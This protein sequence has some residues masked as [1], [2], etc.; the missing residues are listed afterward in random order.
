MQEDATN[1]YEIHQKLGPV[2]C[3]FL[4]IYMYV[5]SSISVLE[6]VWILVD[7]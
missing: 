7:R 2:V 6:E 3:Y 4:Y 1:N 5:S